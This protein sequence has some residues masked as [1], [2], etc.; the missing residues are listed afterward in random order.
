MRPDKAGFI[1]Q[2]S[3]IA[4]GIYLQAIEVRAGALKEAHEAGFFYAQC[5]NQPVFLTPL[6]GERTVLNPPRQLMSALK[7]QGELG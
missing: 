6:E 7:R 5:G 2:Y 3:E 1:M 4:G